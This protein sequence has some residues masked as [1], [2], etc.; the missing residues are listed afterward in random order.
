MYGEI[1][2]DRRVLPVFMRLIE[3]HVF[4]H[5]FAY[6][7]GGDEY[8]ILLPNLSKPLA[9]NFLESLRNAI[10]GTKYLCT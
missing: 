2:V 7:Y 8:M 3:A 4:Q 1:E 5:G 9:I 6:R 10:S